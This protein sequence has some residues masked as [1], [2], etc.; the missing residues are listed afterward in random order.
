M[1]VC[2]L[3]QHCQTAVCGVG[4]AS[5][6]QQQQLPLLTC[7][8]SHF[9]P[10][11]GCVLSGSLFGSGSLVKPRPQAMG[12]KWVHIRLFVKDPWSDAPDDPRI[13]TESGTQGGAQHSVF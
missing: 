12:W 3:S 1:L 4:A 11:G 8:L 5:F 6:P 2:S 9:A 13:P 10:S 7:S